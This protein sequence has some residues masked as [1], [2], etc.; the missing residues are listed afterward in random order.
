MKIS[1]GPNIINLKNNHYESTDTAT[2][3]YNEALW[4]GSLFQRPTGKPWNG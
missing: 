1:E 3:E 2:N 4:Y